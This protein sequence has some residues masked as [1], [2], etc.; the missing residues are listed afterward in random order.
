MSEINEKDIQKRFDEI[1]KYTISPE[2]TT[3]DLERVRRI[4]TERAVAPRVMRPTIWRMIMKSRITKLSATAVIIIGIFV[5]VGY[6]NVDGTSVAWAQVAQKVQQ[7]RSYMYRGQS[8]VTINMQGTQQITEQETVAYVDSEYGTRKELYKNEKLS[9]V[10]YMNP[11]K[12]WVVTVAPETKSYARVKIPDELLAKMQQKSNDPRANDPRA[13]V[14]KYTSFGYTELGRSTI[15]GI[16]VEGIAVDD[17]RIL[18]G[19]FDSFKGRLWVDVETDLP[20]RIEYECSSRNGE[21]QKQVTMSEFQW[22]LELDP[23]EFEPNIPDD[24]TLMAEVKLPGTKDEGK[25]VEALRLFSKIVD[26]KYPSS[27]DMMIPTKEFSEAIEETQ[28]AIYALTD[29]TLREEAEKSLLETLGL[30][31]YKEPGPELMKEH[32]KQTTNMMM[33]M[34]TPAVFYMQ[35][36]SLGNDPAYYGDRVTA[37]D[38]DAV[39]LRWKV[40]DSEYRVIFGDLTTRDVTAEQLAELEKASTQ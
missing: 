15:D 29:E 32:M 11:H 2:M 10:M 18:G 22:G 25:V 16:E 37:E 1:S 36:V 26:G 33:T 27:L 17:P 12:E 30:K 19:R 9:S 5:G 14:K 8:S 35:L 23:K 34:Q 38:V 7:I 28:K 3:R 24:Y 31:V 6:F 21:I 13:I 39:L 40:S 4:L 20:V